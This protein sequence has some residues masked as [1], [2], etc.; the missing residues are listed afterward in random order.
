MKDIQNYLNINESGAYKF[1]EY[2]VYAI[3]DLEE[4]N[5]FCKIYKSQNDLIKNEW[6]DGLLLSE[7]NQFKDVNDFKAQIQK[8]NIDNQ[9]EIQDIQYVDIRIFKID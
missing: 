7:S 2:I 3:G 4:G 5:G 8:T 6:E 1:G 9:L